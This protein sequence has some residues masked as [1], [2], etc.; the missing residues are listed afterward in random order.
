MTII[1]S[2]QQVPCI[3]LLPGCSRDVGET[4]VLAV[5]AV[6]AAANTVVAS[7]EADK[8]VEG[9]ELV[10]ERV[11]HLTYTDSLSAQKYNRITRFST[12]NKDAL[13]IVPIS[14]TAGSLA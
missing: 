10:L 9:A 3:S 1:P 12:L 7:S 13:T 14:E 6:V 4:A 11:A 2:Q 8:A 5:A